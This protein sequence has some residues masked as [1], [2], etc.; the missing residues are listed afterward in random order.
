[1]SLRELAD[2]TL[3]LVI[4]CFVFPH[5][6]Y[7]GDGGTSK[8]ECSAPKMMREGAHAAAC[9]D[10]LSNGRAWYDHALLTRCTTPNFS[11]GC[12]HFAVWVALWAA[13]PLLG[14]AAPM[15]H[16]G[17]LGRAG[18]ECGFAAATAVFPFLL[19]SVPGESS[20]CGRSLPAELV[21]DTVPV[22]ALTPADRALVAEF[23]A[24]GPT[25]LGE[26]LEVFHDLR[27]STA[28]APLVAELKGMLERRAAPFSQ[29]IREAFEVLVGAARVK[30]SV[31]YSEARIAAHE[32]KRQEDD[33]MDTD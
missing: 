6:Y 17:Q 14:V 21:N 16:A 5:V 33:P 8:G 32:A 4:G 26:G 31:K 19:P 3:E 25:A 12:L 7:L 18:I 9:V 30:D 15:T 2:A 20:D 29:N 10:A 13:A 24:T 27:D 11:D 22:R 1:M 23:F 28:F